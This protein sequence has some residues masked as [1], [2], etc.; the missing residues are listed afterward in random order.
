LLID[1]AKPP[2]TADQSRHHIA[3]KA[4][5]KTKKEKKKKKKKQKRRPSSKSRYPFKG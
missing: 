3:L 2:P 1:L 5:L 4:R